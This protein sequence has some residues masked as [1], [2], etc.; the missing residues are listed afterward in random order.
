MNPV[1]VTSSVTNLVVYTCRATADGGDER[2]CTQSTQQSLCG[3]VAP[4]SRIAGLR[5]SLQVLISSDPAPSLLGVVAQSLRL[6][7]TIDQAWNSSSD[8]IHTEIQ[9]IL[10]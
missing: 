5:K 2:P 7:A 8:V 4:S 9:Q 1:A 3:V 10:P 6:A